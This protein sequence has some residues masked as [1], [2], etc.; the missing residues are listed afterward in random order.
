MPSR[1]DNDAF[2]DREPTPLEQ[3]AL[4]WVVRVER[5][6]AADQERELA[7][8]LAAHPRHRE[9]FAEFGGTWTLMGRVAGE[10]PAGVSGVSVAER[11]SSETLAF[12]SSSS[13]PAVPVALWRRRAFWMPVAAAAAIAIAGVSWR[14]QPA[15]QGVVMATEVGVSREMALPDGSSV[16]LNTN[17]TVVTSFTATE[18]RVRLEKGEAYFQVAKDAARPFVVDAAGVGVRAVGTAFNV[19]VH[20]TAIEVLV[21]EGTVRV[22][23]AP[24]VANARNPA[25]EVGAGERVFVPIGASDAPVATA[26]TSSGVARVPADEVQR[27]LAWQGR[28]LDCSDTPLSEM[29]A[30]F[31]RYNRHQLAVPDAA[32]AAM[33]FGGSFRPDD[34]EGFV[35]MLRDNFGILAEERGELTVLRATR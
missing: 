35:R 9:L 17:S 19:R 28:R 22:G 15:A 3:A 5:G 4:D 14:P 12:D 6:L 20:A 16:E 8:W 31:N 24:L 10:A 25:L 11:S 18:R 1:P 29:V 33:R 27:R 21:T 13:T 30:E 32:L 34:R 26:A 23:S 2:F 7:G